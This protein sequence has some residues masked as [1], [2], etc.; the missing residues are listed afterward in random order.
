MRTG[1]TL[2]K[3]APFHVGHQL[4]IE[5]ALGEVDRL[6]VVV[7]DA[8]AHTRVPLDRRVSWIRALYPDVEV[9]RGVDGPEVTGLT[10]EIV[11][12]Q[13]DYLRG[14]LRGREVDAFFSSEPYGES[15]ARALGA[16]NRLVDSARTRRPVSGTALR[17]ALA[18]M[19]AS[20]AQSVSGIR[21]LWSRPAQLAIWAGLTLVFALAM[22]AVVARLHLWLPRLFPVAAD[23]P[24]LDALTTVM[25][26]VAM[27]LM[28][29][30][31]TESWIYWIVVD[32]IGIGLYWVKDVRFISIQYVALLA[33]AIYGFL[34]WVR[35]APP[36]DEP[37]GTVGDAAVDGGNA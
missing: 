34:R 25:S 2:G 21:S 22:T 10:L 24:F 17:A 12:V 15:V 18:A 20:A 35:E 29:R 27:F 9:I 11:E 19:P 7:Y 13:N 8:H 28:A 6:V 31:R 36:V 26:F 33:M 23:Y 3:F 32:V 14:L 37:S 16:R 30:R 4:V 5:T 1:L